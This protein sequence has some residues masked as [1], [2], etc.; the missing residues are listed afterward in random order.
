[1]IFLDC[2]PI[3]LLKFILSIYINIFFGARFPTNSPASCS[4]RP[5]T[6]SFAIKYKSLSSPS[7]NR[8]CAYVPKET[9]ANP[10]ST[11]HKVDRDIPA[12]S[13]TCSAL[14]LLLKQASFIFA[15]ISSS[16]LVSFGSSTVFVL[17]IMFYIS[18]KNKYIVLNT[19][20]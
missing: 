13:A 8:T 20:H 6:S 15:P 10:F 19:K 17:F 4:F 7:M 16:I 3:L 12:R 14:N 9:L 11:Y 1:M 5:K 18:N 2:N